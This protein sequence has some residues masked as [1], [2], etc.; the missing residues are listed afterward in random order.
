MKQCQETHISQSFRIYAIYTLNFQQSTTP[1]KLKHFS[2]FVNLTAQVALKAPY[3]WKHANLESIRAFLK[4][5]V[6]KG[7]YKPIIQHGL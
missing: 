2:W 7:V 1:L 6:A 3:N 4:A 5:E